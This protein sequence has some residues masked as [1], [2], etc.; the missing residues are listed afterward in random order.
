MALLDEVAEGPSAGQ[1]GMIK[2]EVDAREQ[3]RLVRE[4]LERDPLRRAWTSTPAPGIASSRGETE[5]VHEGLLDALPAAASGLENGIQTVTSATGKPTRVKARTLCGRELCI[6][7]VSTDAVSTLKG[8]IADAVGTPTYLLTLLLGT[9]VL[10]DECG[11][12][13]YNLGDGAEVTIIIERPGLRIDF[14]E[15]S[16]HE[17][18]GGPNRGMVRGTFEGRDVAIKAL[19]TEIEPAEFERVVALLKRLRHPRLVRFIGACHEPPN[20]CIVTEYMPAATL[21]DLLHRDIV[22]SLDQQLKIALQVCEGLAVLHGMIP[23][24][25]KMGLGPLDIWLDGHYNAK[26]GDLGSV[27][28]ALGKHAMRGAISSRARYM[29]PELYD[30]RGRFTDKTDVWSVGCI[31]IELFGGLVPYGDCRSIQ[32]VLAMVLIERRVPEIPDNLPHGL[33]PIV[34]DCLHYETEQRSSVW[35]VLNRLQLLRCAL[36]DG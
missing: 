20:L 31:L 2:E 15:L 23:C 27:Q 25:V 13:E 29:A 21:F 6:E 17:G 35:E 7:V 3:V 36:F 11:L 5:E 30:C 19:G 14:S 32:E 22:L 34:A 12:G 9:L 24:M 16:L 28:P 33:R 10:E 18:I 4:M 1:A 26:I 8:T